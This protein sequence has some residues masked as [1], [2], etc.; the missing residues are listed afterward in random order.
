MVPVGESGLVA[1]FRIAVAP[2]CP[3]PSTLTFQLRLQDAGGYQADLEFEVPVGAWVDDVEGDHGWTLGWPGD[4]A[5]TGMWVRADPVG[6]TYNGQQA[7]PEDDHTINPGVTCFVTGNG[8]PGGAA[9]D[10]D[11]DGGSTTLMSPVF[12]LHGATSAMLTYWRWYTNNLGTN[13]DQDWW[14]VDVSSDGSSWVHL[15][16]TTN[17]ANSWSLF[18]FDLTHYTAMTDE[19]RVRFIASDLP[20]G[21]LVEAAVDDISLSVVKTPDVAVPPEQV[22]AGNGIVQFGPNP[23]RGNGNVVFRTAAPGQARIEL[24]DVSGRM[25]RR[26]YNG[27]IGAGTHTVPLNRGTLAS[28]IYF[29][30]VETD[31]IVEFRQMAI[32][33]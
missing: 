14:D 17:S 26:F 2:D 7:Q 6:T 24:Y 33:R 1:G 16:H 32:L 8:V 18:S 5:T 20:L 28:G 22:R 21:T 4:D 25:V 12:H 9:G 23:L 30:R 10:S 29:L 3:D 13:P 11:V 27:P 31:R 15:E 19:V